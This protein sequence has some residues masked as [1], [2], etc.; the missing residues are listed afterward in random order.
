[1]FELDRYEYFEDVNQGVLRRAPSGGAR[2]L[3]VGCGSGLLG[4]AITA[5]GNEV[6]GIDNAEAIAEVAAS[7]LHRFLLADVTSADAVA[8][9]LGEET[10]DV[11]VFAD[12]LEHVFDPVGMLS[13]YRR[14]L[15][16]GG[17]VIVSVPN[18]G[19]WSVRLALLSGRFD[20]AQT[21]TLDKT[22]VRFFT[23]RTLTRALEAAG[24]QLQSVDVTPGLIRPFV[25]LLKR[26]SAAAAEGDRRAIIDSWQYRL[27]LRVFYPVE[28]RLAALAPGLLAFQYI[29]VAGTER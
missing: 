18:V 24:L 17:H 7:R 21:G 15:K 12:V 2:V 27:Y 5:R 19:I 9:A 13:S 4:A 25:P 29:A 22:H 11:L 16:P 3:D 14:F 10:F 26:R 23:R 28:R 8:A 6:W 1:M 20:Y